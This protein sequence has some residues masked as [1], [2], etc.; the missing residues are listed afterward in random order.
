[1]RSR[2]RVHTYIYIY[3]HTHTLPGGY[4]C[5]VYMFLHWDVEY[6]GLA[7]DAGINYENSTGLLLKNLNKVTIMGI[8]SN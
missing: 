3:T 6:S 1:M 4:F 7:S 8:Y 2:P 5:G